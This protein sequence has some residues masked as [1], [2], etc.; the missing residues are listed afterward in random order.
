MEQINTEP[1]DFKAVYSKYNIWAPTSQ[2]ENSPGFELVKISN[3][4]RIT[5]S[6]LTIGQNGPREYTPQEIAQSQKVWDSEKQE[7]MD[8]P[9]DMFSF[10]KLFSDFTG[11]FS[12]NFSSTK[13]MATYDEDVDING[14]KRGEIGFD[15]SQIEHQ[16][17]DYMLNENGTY[18]Y[19][20]LKDGENI[21]GK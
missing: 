12:D 17:G 11:F 9:E 4:D 15:E 13:V 1:Q 14:K 20:T 7:W 18:Y 16:K 19:R 8:T 3:P 2:R 5:K 10:N 6:M 21:Y